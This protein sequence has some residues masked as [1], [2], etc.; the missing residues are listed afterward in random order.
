ML[1][2]HTPIR[3]LLCP[4]LLP[5]GPPRPSQACPA[6]RIPLQMPRTV[7]AWIRSCRWTLLLSTPWTQT[8]EM[9]KAIGSASA[10]ARQ[11][12]R[13][14]LRQ[15]SL[16]PIQRPH[17]STSRDPTHTA[18]CRPLG[19]C[20][21]GEHWGLSAGRRPHEQRRSWITGPRGVLYSLLL[22]SQCKTTLIAVSRSPWA[23]YPPSSLC[24]AMSCSFTQIQPERTHVIKLRRCYGGAS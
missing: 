19:I 13:G 1:P 9:R 2:C 4:T 3:C 10:R 20:T 21:K 12:P 8:V 22:A 18:S 11:L 7:R 15:Q 6:H 14:R 17:C 23:P 5:A 24:S 16:L